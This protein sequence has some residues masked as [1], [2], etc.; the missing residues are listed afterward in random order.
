MFARSILRTVLCTLA[1]GVTACASSHTASPIPSFSTVV[2][3][4]EAHRVALRHERCLR[5]EDT[6]YRAIV[7]NAGTPGAATF[8]IKRVVRAA[9]ARNSSARVT[10]TSYPASLG[11]I[12]SG[13]SDALS[14][15]YHPIP[16]GLRRVLRQ[17]YAIRPGQFSFLPPPARLTYAVIQREA[18]NPSELPR[19]IA[20]G[21]RRAGPAAGWPRL[22][23]SQYASL[24]ATG[25]LTRAE[26]GSVWGAIASLPQAHVCRDLPRGQVG[27]CVSGDGT[28]TQMLVNRR[29]ASVGAVYDRLVGTAEPELYPGLPAHAVVGADIFVRDAPFSD[30]RCRASE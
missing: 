28:E 24:L 16:L 13:T 5:F 26:S 1:L 6:E 9:V 22:L 7:S 12:F 10:V 25:P 19:S 20:R 23:L 29:T 27:I 18:V 4:A 15:L 30:P 2:R 17:T 11:P 3:L 14:S 21:V 8:F